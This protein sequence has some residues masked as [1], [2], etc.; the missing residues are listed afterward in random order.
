MR[1]LQPV[2]DLVYMAL[3]SVCKY[4]FLFTVSTIKRGLF[5]ES[6]FVNKG[7]TCMS[8]F[9]KRGLFCMYLLSI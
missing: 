5:C 8:L 7:L 2:H 3:K 4:S 6:L 9:R 1:F